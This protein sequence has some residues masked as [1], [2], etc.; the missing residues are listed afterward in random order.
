MSARRALFAAAVLVAALLAVA[1]SASGATRVVVPGC[2]GTDKARYKPTTV[3]VLC[4]DGNFK[5]VRISW[6]SWTQTQ[7]TGRGTARVNNCMPNC[8]DGSFENYRVKLVASRKK[9]CSNGKLEFVRLTYSFPMTKPNGARR[10]G[11]LRRPCS[12]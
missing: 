11:T 4:D 9:E 12:R 2:G 7:A 10:S 1:V 3:N 5:V 8:D 6:S